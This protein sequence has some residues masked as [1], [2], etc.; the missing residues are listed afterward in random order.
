MPAVLDDQSGLVALRIAHECNLGAA[1]LVG[2]CGSTVSDCARN[3][4]VPAVSPARRAGAAPRTA[5]RR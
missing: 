4:K 5:Q 3:V 1:V 2:K